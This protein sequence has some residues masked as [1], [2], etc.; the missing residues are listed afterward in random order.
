MQ[1]RSNVFD[2]GPALYKCYTSGLCLLGLYS[3]FQA[4]FKPEK[5][6]PTLKNIY[7]NNFA[8]I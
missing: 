5:I 4:S 8:F 3:C 7:G 2:V 1:P 6:P